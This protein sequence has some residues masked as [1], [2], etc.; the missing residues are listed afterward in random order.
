M[1]KFCG[2]E[3]FIESCEIPTKVENPTRSDTFPEPGPHS[4]ETMDIDGVSSSSH[5]ERLTPP[6]EFCDSPYHQQSESS[7]NFDYL[8]KIM[9]SRRA[10]LQESYGHVDDRLA[11][12]RCLS[13]YQTANFF[14]NQ[15]CFH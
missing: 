8:D 6:R 12:D 4:I 14:P 11:I 1:D 2:K 10:G 9:E 3:V 13:L 15:S 7:M 5:T